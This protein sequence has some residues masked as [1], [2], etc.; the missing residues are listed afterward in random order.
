MIEQQ[1]WETKAK[2]KRR[3]TEEEEM[4]INHEKEFYLHYGKPQRIADSVKSKSTTPA[5]LFF[6]L[7]SIVLGCS[8]YLINK[9][10]VSERG[11]EVDQYVKYVEQW[12]NLY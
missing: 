3:L 10:L 1:K 6:C 4:E 11:H 5:C 7:G 2:Q 8:I 12:S 9:G